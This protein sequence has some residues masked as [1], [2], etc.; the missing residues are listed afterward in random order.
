MRTLGLLRFGALFCGGLLGCQGA[1]GPAGA[2]G[3]K[4][5]D[6]QGC[7]LSTAGGVKTFACPDGSTFTVTDGTNGADGQSCTLT[8]AGGVKTFTCPDGSTFTVTDGTSGQ[9]CWDLNGNGTGDVATEDKNSDGVVGVADCAGQFPVEPAGVVGM[10]TEASG[11]S[12]GGGMVY[13]VPAAD[14]AALPA[15]TI[16]VGS[17]DDE[18][19]EDTIAA[20]GASYQKAAVAA[21]GRYALPTLTAGSYFVTFV[22]DALDDAHLPGGSA[23]RNAM[24]STN[25]VGTRLDIRISDSV[26][27]DAYFVGSGACVSCHGRTHISETMHRIGIWSSYES[28]RLQDFAPRFDDL[29]QAITT[30]FEVPG[31]T[32]VYFYDYDATRGF[33]KYK[34]AETDPTG[35]GGVVS[36][37]VTVRKTGVDLEMVYNNVKNPSD[38][39]NGKVYRVDAVY[40]GGVL[41]QRYMTR[42][43]PN[44]PAAPAPFYAMLPLQF[45]HEGDEALPYGRT[46]KVW[47]DYNGYKWFTEN[48]GASVFK[49]PGTND[50]FEKNCISCHAAGVQVTGDATAGFTASMVEDTFFESGDFDYDGDGIANEV[51]VGCES[52]HGPGSRHWDAAGQ[53]KHIVALSLLTPE[54]EAMVCGQ[55]HS[56]PKG[57]LGTD[58][59]I[60]AAGWMMRAGTSRNEFLTS[61]ATTQLDGAASDYY[62][63][64]DKHS[65]SHH[66]QYSDF[67]RSA[68]YKNASKL[69]TC[70]GCH[71]PHQRTTNARQLRVDPLDNAAACGSCH[72]TQSSDLSAHITSKFGAA[73]AS[74]ASFAACVDCHMPKTAKTGAGQPGA[75]LSSV[76]YWMNDI[77][78]HLFKVPDRALATSQSMPVPYTSACGTCHAAAP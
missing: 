8:T 59:P 68:M 2:D 76:Q 50:S 70:S 41:K 3:T 16:A 77:T 71:D 53:S 78:S 36:F 67:I 1:T 69:M 33:D 48:D 56:R 38:P 74:K 51:N 46:S 5:A 63:D 58:S 43:D 55:C 14:V 40:G 44:G 62:A 73:A 49:E 28:G 45:Q 19:L 10:V 47:R 4:G 27:E 12:V 60:N 9:A 72:S 15:T 52:C 18:P 13:F 31:G 35:A 64:S 54:R 30:K 32:T 75:V 34:T 39:N 66:Q 37:T 61:Y 29:Y 23:C 20:N 57:A 65:K 24:D 17:P 42:L 21:D 11:A 6:G 22:P 25:L 26:P 7:T